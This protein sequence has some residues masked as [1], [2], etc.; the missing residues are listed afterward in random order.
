[1]PNAVA[2]MV[3]MMAYMGFG[4]LSYQEN[5]S[6]MSG[7]LGQKVVSEDINIWDN[8]LD[9]RTFVAVYDTEGVAKQ[10][11]D[12]IKSGVATG[13]FDDS[14]TA[15]REGKKSTGH[16]FGGEREISGSDLNL[17]LAPGS[18]RVDDMISNTKRGLLVTR[19]HYTN[20]AH[21]MTA[22]ITGMTRD[23]TFLVE[24]GRIVGPVK[25]MRFTQSVLEALSCVDMIGRD[26]ELHGGVLVPALKVGKFR[27]SSATQF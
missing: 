9:P 16:A 11:V 27:F 18:A 1:M 13:L 20:V 26:L 17:I 3:G 22:T 21:L 10:C 12:L 6:F 25:N 24:D 15:H 8:G 5:R 7:K 4:A 19:F 14:Y 2:D 23:G